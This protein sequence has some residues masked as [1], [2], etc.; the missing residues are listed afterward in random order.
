[1][2]ESI[3]GTWVTQLV[4]VFML[5]FVAFLTL[6]INY[7]KAYR[8]KNQTISIIEKRQGINST[9]IRY[10][11]SYL[12][13]SG[14][15]TKGYCG[16]DVKNVY[17]IDSLDDKDITLTPA[18]KNVKYYYCIYKID[19]KSN[20]FKRKANYGVILFFKFNLPVIGDITTFSVDGETK[21]I[22]YPNEWEGS[23]DS[24]AR[25]KCN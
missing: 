15:N 7:S 14:Y 17:G 2:R 23:C 19:N 11:N 1:M 9:T 12:R 20:N 3:G 24:K 13:S 10:I 4:I 5:L 18:K 16:K 22:I 25:I 6:S 8:V 21:D